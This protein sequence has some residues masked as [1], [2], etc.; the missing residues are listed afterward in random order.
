MEG[1]FQN[2]LK[3]LKNRV[4]FKGRSITGELKISSFADGEMEVATS[5]VRGSDVYLLSGSAR[6]AA[7]LSVEECKMELYHSVDA[8]RR[9]QA[10]RI[11]LLEPFASP[12]R[13]D[14]TTRRNSVGIWVHYKILISLGVNHIITYNL[15]SDQSRAIIDP[16]KAAI[17]D[18]PIESLIK[19]YIADNFVKNRTTLDQYVPENWAFCSVDAGGEVLAKKFANAFNAPLVIAHKQ[20]DYSKVNTVESVRILTSTP[21]K[22]KV[23]WIVDDMIDTAGSVNKLIEELAKLEPKEINVAIVHPVFSNP[24]PERLSKL[25]KKGI[26]SNI[27]TS[28]TVDCSKGF[29]DFKGHLH[30]VSS[31]DIASDVIYRLNQE[32]SL[33]SLFTPFNA[34]NHLQ[35]K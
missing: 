30:V 15:H 6:N 7:G 26:L 4:A 23:L 20:R 35:N 12:G 14:R 10:E 5:S 1:Y 25:V 11:T 31:A 19:R 8:L 29:E 27:V 2:T 33:S 18:L 28:D 24:A 13:S 16:T 17:D 9:A 34:H 21:L 32:R 22:G 3:Y